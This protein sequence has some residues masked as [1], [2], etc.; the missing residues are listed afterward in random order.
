[1]KRRQRLFFTLPAISIA[2]VALLV[3]AIWLQDGVGG[4]GAR[5]ALVVLLPGDNQAAVFQEQ[6][7]RSGLLFG[8]SFPLPEDVVCASVPTDD[9]GPGGRTFTFERQENTASGDWFRSRARQAQHLR[10]LVPTR[11]RV[12]QVGT[13]PDGAPIVQSSVGTTLRNFRLVDASGAWEAREVPSGARVTL[14]RSTSQEEPGKRA[15]Q[16]GLACSAHFRYLVHGCLT[17]EPGRF[18]ASTGDFELAPIATL[19]GIRWTA[20]DVMITGLLDNAGNR[21]H[22]P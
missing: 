1:V 22:S 7:S 15:S 13:A 17:E 19:P 9:Y 4:D 8:A 3:A 11:A 6:V 16:F 12:E 20:S 2:A 18:V 5:R 14:S 21:S 10:R